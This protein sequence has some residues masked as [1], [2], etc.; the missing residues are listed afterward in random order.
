MANEISLSFKLA[1]TKNSVTV[2][3]AVQT[4]VQTMQSDLDA[5]RAITQEVA[6]AT[7]E[8]VELGDVD[9]TN[10]SGADYMLAMVNRDSTAA[11]DVYVGFD[12]SSSQGYIHV[13]QMKPGEP[14]GPVRLQKATEDTYH[15]GNIF[16]AGN[17]GTALVE[18][19]AVACGNPSA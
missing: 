1:A 11:V 7:K 9:A 10:A 8:A 3:N 19:I 6:S 13:G 16:I 5:M 12:D 14:W 4:K 17:G 18:V 2:Q 15:T